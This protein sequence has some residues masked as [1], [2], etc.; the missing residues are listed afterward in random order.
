MGVL[1]PALLMGYAFF[2]HDWPGCRAD[3]QMLLVAYNLLQW[4]VICHNG[5]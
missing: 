2:F 5:V 3:A 4:R 1:P